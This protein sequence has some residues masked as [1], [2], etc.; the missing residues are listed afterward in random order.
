MR[1]F[2]GHSPRSP[3]WGGAR[4][5]LSRPH[6]RGG[7]YT[8]KCLGH[9]DILIRPCRKYRHSIRR[10]RKLHPRTKHGVN[11]MIGRGDIAI[12]IFQGGG[13]AAKTGNSAIRSADLEN[14]TVEP[15]MKWIGRSLAEIWPYEFFFQMWGRRSSVGRRSVGPQC[16]QGG[17]KK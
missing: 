6:S 9:H 7:T 8:V 16:I 5:P 10:P 14:P 1:N 3:Y 15:N 13:R 2:L 17:P 12:W 11:R 4:A